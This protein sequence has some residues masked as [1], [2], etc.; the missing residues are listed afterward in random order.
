MTLTRRD[1]IKMFGIGL[2]SFLVSRCQAV[3]PPPFAA[4]DRLRGLWLG[5]PELANKTLAG[6]NDEDELGTRMIAEHQAALGSVVADGNL[7]PE[8]AELVQEAYAA[9]VYHVWRSNAPITCYAPVM[10]DYAPTGAAVLVKQ[11]EILGEL[12]QQG[13]VDPA[14]LANAQAALEHDLAFYELTDD[15]TQALYQAVIES[16]QGSGHAIP[17]FDALELELTPEAREAAHFILDLLSSK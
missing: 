10:V 3:A 4:R 14:I 17:S 5:F 2:A 11:S 7:S 16:N 13:S 15:Q 9:A 1:F 12:A 6:R 8:A